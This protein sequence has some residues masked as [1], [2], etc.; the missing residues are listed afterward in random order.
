MK[1][2]VLFFTVL[3]LLFL[4]ACSSGEPTAPTAVNSSGSE[5]DSS[6]TTSSV[7]LLTSAVSRA[8]AKALTTDTTAVASPLKET[9]T[10]PPTSA[11]SVLSKSDLAWLEA[12]FN[13][14][15]NNG[16]VTKI[17]TEPKNV[18]LNWIFYSG[19]GIGIPIPS[20]EKQD[21]IKNDQ[22][23]GLGETDSLKLPASAVNTFLNNKLGLALSQFPAGSFTY[24]Y[25][26]KYDAY[27][28]VQVD[29]NFTTVKC[30]NGYKQKDELFVVTVQNS[31]PSAHPFTNVVS[32]KVVNTYFRYVSCVP[33]Y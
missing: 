17:F 21:L 26:Q 22:V 12:D 5:A 2:S 27:Y 3:L 20:A 7:T 25:V 14:P 18:D 15:A 11:F 6:T 1:K 28:A 29:S 16:F 4:T 10:R 23:P 33:A 8:T 19:G 9:T 31:D 30:L 24:P 13:N 32:F